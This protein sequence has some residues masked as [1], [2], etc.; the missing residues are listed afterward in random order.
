MS[1]RVAV[2]GLLMVGALGLT[3]C[4]ST[5]LEKARMFEKYLRSPRYTFDQLPF[6]DTR[7]THYY[8]ADPKVAVPFTEVFPGVKVAITP[9]RID[10]A[11]QCLR[12]MKLAYA[13]PAKQQAY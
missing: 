3:G 7:I 1:Y 11:H 5:K 13:A 2:C 6:P 8:D 9:R 12:A 10:A 4:V